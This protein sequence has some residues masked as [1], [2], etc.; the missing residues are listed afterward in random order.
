MRVVVNVPAARVQVL[1]GNLLLRVFV[2]VVNLLFIA[3]HLQP[4]AEIID[5]RVQAL[6][7][8]IEKFLHPLDVIRA[9]RD[10]Q[11]AENLRRR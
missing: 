5:E 3:H 8:V 4:K 7:L 10:F 1:T 2:I 9:Q 6:V 11:V